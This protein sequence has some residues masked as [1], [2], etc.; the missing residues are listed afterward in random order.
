MSHDIAMSGT[1]ANEIAYACAPHKHTDSSALKKNEIVKD[2]ET[3]NKKIKRTNTYWKRN[4]DK[5][6][7]RK[8]NN[9]IDLKLPTTNIVCVYKASSEHSE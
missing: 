6:F 4:E 8:E 1:D 5:T 3:K 7:N 9:K 2:E